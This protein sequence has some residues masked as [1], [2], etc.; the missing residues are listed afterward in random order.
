MLDFYALSLDLVGQFQ[1]QIS[2]LRELRNGLLHP[3][4][5]WNTY[6]ALF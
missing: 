2:K 6:K 5:H 3:K 1:H 4:E